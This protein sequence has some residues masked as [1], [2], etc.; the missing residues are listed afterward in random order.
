[1][2][3]WQK[4]AMCLGLLLGLV[5]LTG[6]QADEKDKKGD[7]GGKGAKGFQGGKGFQFGQQQDLVS[8]ELQEKLKLTADQKEKINKLNK[9][10]TDKTKP[11]ADKLK[12]S[13][14]KGGKEGFEKIR[15][16]FQDLQ[17][18]RTE[19]TDKVKTVLTEE[20]KKT[21]DENRRTRPGFGGPGGFGQGGFG[22][23][24]P[25]GR[26]ADTSIFSSSVQE[27]LGLNAD[28]KK[29]LEALKKELDEKSVGV[30]TAEQK[31]K[32]EELQKD[33]GRRPEGRRPSETK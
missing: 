15:E 9:E 29:K 12:D 33:S 10:F 23:G 22:Q 18:I 31:K 25:G 30:L 27:K 11:I 1:M 6:V 13:A 19:F 5:L 8:T 7:K 16:Q 4:S 24:G 28:Q 14:G 20:Q 3:L 21:F 2:R 17:K 32:L 26:Q